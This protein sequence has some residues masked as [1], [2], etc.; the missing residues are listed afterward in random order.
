M[1]LRT[2]AILFCLV[3]PFQSVQADIASDVTAKLSLQ[4][5]VQNAVSAGT[6]V[7]DIVTQ[8]LAVTDTSK[9]VAMLTEL[10]ALLPGE[11]DTILAAAIVA[12]IDPGLV[13]QATA[14]GNA[15]STQGTFTS[16]S[17]S[18][19]Y[20]SAGGGGGGGNASPS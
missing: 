3:M 19:N 7:T 6:T 13:G 20:Q 14:A 8:L 2:L 16:G 11:S 4:E 9:Q 17:F 1:K 5:V 18:S 10:N 15:G 12:G